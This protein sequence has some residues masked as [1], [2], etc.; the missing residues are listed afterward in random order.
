MTSDISQLLPLAFWSIVTLV[1]AVWTVS[2][3]NL[4]RAALSLGLVLIGVAGIFVVL[5]A[6]PD[7]FLPGWLGNVGHLR[8]A[9]W[10]LMM[11]F[12]PGGPRPA[13][14]RVRPRRLLHL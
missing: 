8:A 5:A 4:F 10:P 11:A 2:L 1:G 12:L 13:W 9:R 7:M 14:P 3:R 6:E